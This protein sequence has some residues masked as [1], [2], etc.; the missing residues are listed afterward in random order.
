MDAKVSQ[1]AMPKVGQ[2]GFAT[3]QKKQMEGM[4]ANLGSGNILGDMFSPKIID[5]K[6]AEANK[7][8]MADVKKE[9][10][11]PAPPAPKPAEKPA[12]PK[13]VNT[14]IGIKDLNDQLK[15]LNMNMLKLISHSETTSAASE[16]TAKNSAKATGNRYA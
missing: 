10:P 2:A 12:E 11:K 1:E 8:K 7:A 16:K 13:P 5:K 6:L 3:E 14:E 15:M 4:F 9:E